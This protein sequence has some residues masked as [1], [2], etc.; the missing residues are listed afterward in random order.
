M[1]LWQHLSDDKNQIEELENSFYETV[2]NHRKFTPL[3]NVDLSTITK[4]PSID[5]E[6]FG[7]LK[8]EMIRFCKEKNIPITRVKEEEQQ[9]DE[10]VFCDIDEE[11]LPFKRK[12][13]YL[14]R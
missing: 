13:N 10:T 5:F 3:K 8:A 4:P 2:K 7:E 1:F 14:N 9:Q 6:V 11:M 12:S